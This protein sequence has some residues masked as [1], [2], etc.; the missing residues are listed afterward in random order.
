MLIFQLLAYSP[1]A[2]A[3]GLP[4]PLKPSTS[5]TSN[6][7]PKYNAGVDQSIKDYLCTPN[8]NNLGVGLYDCITRLYKFGISFG[9]IVLVFFVVYAGYLYIIS[10]EKGKGSAKNYISSAITG[11][12][13][14]LSSYVLLN[15]ISPELVKFKPIQPPIFSAADLPKCEDIGFSTN[16]IVGDPTSPNVGQVVYSGKTSGGSCR[17]SNTAGCAVGV[18]KQCSLWNPEDASR[19]CNLESG[20]GTKLN[21]ASGSDKCTADGT[22]F[23]YGLWQF[24]LT[25]HQG[26]SYMPAA[27][28]KKL[29]SGVNF[30]CRLIVSKAELDACVN[31]LGTAEAQTKA[32][33]GLYQ[34]SKFNPWKCS[35]FRCQISGYGNPNS[36]YCPA[37]FPAR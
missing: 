5:V 9:A 6:D 28:Q 32:A 15:F 37:T 12:I 19:I 33:C 36:K 27:C 3:Q 18:M 34:Q 16:C 10:G 13:I 24:N 35:A 11:M 1:Y 30:G 22:P 20:G 29:F 31:A 21:I 7:L 2:Q 8:D 23:S 14:I 17:I 4:D 25:V 26:Q